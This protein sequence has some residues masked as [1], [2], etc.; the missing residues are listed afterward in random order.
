MP[1]P[2]RRMND[3]RGGGIDGTSGTGGSQEEQQ[4]ILQQ[5]RPTMDMRRDVEQPEF[6]PA[7][8]FR[9]NELMSEP[10][11]KILPREERYPFCIVWSPL[12]PITSSFPYVGHMGICDFA[13]T[14]GTFRGHMQLD[15]IIW[16]S[17]T[18]HGFLKLNPELC[19]G[20]KKD[21]SPA[22]FWDSCL[23]ESN[24]IYS[25]RMHKHML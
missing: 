6:H 14:Y 18:Q 3:I 12:G 4:N 9:E 11:R 7:S 16:R 22:E 17:A 24:C 23:H 10:T 21:Q 2:Q 19:K 15:E 20:R 8:H 5:V 13:G 25:R 1:G